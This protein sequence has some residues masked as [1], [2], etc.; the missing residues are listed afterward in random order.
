METLHSFYQTKRLRLI[1]CVSKFYQ[2]LL[3]KKKKNRQIPTVN[4][5]NVVIGRKIQNFRNSAR[6]LRALHRL[7]TSSSKPETGKIKN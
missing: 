2:L 4:N 5:L 7:S 1:H 6:S 3:K